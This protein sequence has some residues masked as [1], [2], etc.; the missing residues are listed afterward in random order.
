VRLGALLTVV[1]SLAL[2]AAGCGGGDD[3]SSAT[4]VDDWAEGFCTAITTW[5]G[6]LEQAVKPLRNLSSVS[7]DKVE[8]AGAEIRTATDQFTDD[9]QGLGTPETD[10]GD[11]ARQAVD[12]FK[13]TI[14][15]D[16]DDIEQAVEGTSG[17]TG[18]KDAVTAITS[19]L[20]SMQQAFNKM[21]KSIR[22]TDSERKL[23]TAF[24]EADACGTIG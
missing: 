4:P 21:V 22:T 3:E 23:R 8:Q 9:L 5:T 2:M 1:I 17:V 6:Q 11:E 20:T 12:D 24:E 14:D 7:R 19:S 15:D 13:T 16:L 18:I 10:A